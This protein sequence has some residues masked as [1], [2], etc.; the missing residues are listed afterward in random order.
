MNCS[1]NRIKNL[2]PTRIVATKALLDKKIED[3]EVEATM[4]SGSKRS[5]NV[6]EGKGVFNPL[7]A[8]K[9]SESV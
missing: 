6:A 2:V 1:N 3:Y 4:R 7:P 5:R 9:R 8:A